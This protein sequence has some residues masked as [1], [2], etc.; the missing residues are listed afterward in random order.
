MAPSIHS[1]SANDSSSSAADHFPWLD[2]LRFAAALEV[3][4]Y[5]VRTSYFAAFGDLVPAD[6]TLVVRVW[7]A[8]TRFG[9][10]AVV[11]FFVLS[12]FLVGGRSIE[13]LIAGQFRIGDYLVD[14]VTR[15][16]VPYVPA[17]VLTAVAGMMIGKPMTLADWTCGLL[18]LQGVLHPVPEANQ[19]TWSLAYEMWFYLIIASVAAAFVGKSTTSR[20][21]GIAGLGFAALVFC[22]LSVPSLCC[23]LAGAVA[24][25]VRKQN[26][27][28]LAPIL[29]TLLIIAGLVASQRMMEHQTLPLGVFAPLVP[30]RFVAMMILGFGCA[31]WLPRI[32]CLPCTMSKV[33]HL[34][35]ALAGFS[36]SLYLV[37][38]PLI[39][40]MESASTRVREINPHTLGTSLGLIAICM[41]AA[42]LS[43]LLFER[44][45]PVVR[46]WCKAQLLPAR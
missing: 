45:T 10:E 42:Y 2:W 15:I 28:L 35:A 31:A 6:Q 11:L 40:W 20:V 26:A 38:S 25:L 8:L 43:Y 18:S 22:V 23:W 19:A 44:H 29:G 5:H 24:F 1:H 34:G 4:L 14:R 33:E 17:L 13:R 39:L 32:A 41:A 27:T 9:P 12:G 21:V 37:H 46:R 30:S 3:L 16:Y 36:Y 7:F